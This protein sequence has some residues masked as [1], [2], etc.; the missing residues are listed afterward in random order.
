M[1]YYERR[2]KMKM[3]RLFMVFGVMALIRGKGVR[4]FFKVIFCAEQLEF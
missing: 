3:V 2:E 1:K 4:I